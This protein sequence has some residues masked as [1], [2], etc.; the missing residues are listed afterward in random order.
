MNQH[1]LAALHAY[2][3]DHPKDR[4]ALAAYIDCLLEHDDPR[5]E[6]LQW[7][8][9]HPTS[10]ERMAPNP[11]NQQY[12]DEFFA[13]LA[14][15]AVAFFGTPLESIRDTVDWADFQNGSL[16]RF[17]IQRSASSA[18]DAERWVQAPALQGLQSL[19][20]LND[21][22][23]LTFLR[24]FQ[25]APRLHQLAIH[26]AALD[27]QV[28]EDVL[29][30][31]MIHRLSHWDCSD[32]ML[33]DD[34]ARLLAEFLRSYPHTRFTWVAAGNYLTPLAADLLEEFGIPVS[35][36]QRERRGFLRIL[37]NPRDWL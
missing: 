37:P 30:L 14:P 3:L 10:P 21:G 23:P 1:E 5:G 18:T 2:L 16:T 25:N 19:T 31:P 8:F 15:A 22:D 12:Q 7:Q 34:A 9:D 33:T 27:D 17:T 35:V 28:F 24:V 4:A 29:M 26:D 11:G 6:F 20:I 32:C 36:Q 13:R